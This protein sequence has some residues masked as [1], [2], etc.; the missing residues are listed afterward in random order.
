MTPLD[1]AR[2]Y[3]DRG[4]PVFPCRWQGPQRKRPITE[5][6][7]TEAAT[8]RAVIIAWWRQ[9]PDAL[10]GVTTGRA[11]GFIVLDID[12]K[13]GR[14]G[15]DSLAELGHAILPDTPMVHTASGGLHLYFDPGPHLIISTVGTRGHGIGAGLDW[16]GERGYVIS[17]SPNSGY[18]WD[19][20]W[21]LDTAPLAPVPAALLPRVP[22]PRPAAQP[23]EPSDGLSPYADAALDLACRAIITAPQTRLDSL[24][25]PFKGS[26]RG[27]AT[28]ELPIGLKLIDCPVLIEPNGVSASLPSKLQIDR[29]GHQTTDANG[30]PAYAMTAEWRDR[31]VADRF[32][33]AV[34]ALIRATPYLR[35]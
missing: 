33:A 5:H 4:W 21:N 16:R 26:L 17:A 34:V 10:I 24:E 28:L 25:L 29:D 30:K 2:A 15:F 23:I 35:A 14:N 32:S 6:G 20:H 8:D 22:E 7:F 27:F 12:I 19:P 9:W 1:Q 3:A 13:P 18:R 11:S 31:E